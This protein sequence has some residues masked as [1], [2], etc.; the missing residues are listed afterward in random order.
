MR[1]ARASR[2]RARLAVLM[3]LVLVGCAD[4]P[5][6]APASAGTATLDIDG[7]RIDLDVVAC[8]L[9]DGRFPAT[10]PPT[11]SERTLVAAGETTVDGPVA[12]S[13]RRTRDD[14]APQHV[15]TVEISIGD[16]EEA[17]QALVLYRGLDEDSG[18]WS[19]I[20][21]D[22]ADP[23]VTVP[24]PLLELT[25]A[26]LR[27]EGSASMPTDG[28]RVLVRLDARCP[29]EVDGTPGIA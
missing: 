14:V 1:T 20:D 12:V 5:T 18:T 26:S 9:I 16:P 23:R 7:R 21:P 19:E 10:P 29:I 2:R 3:A 8:G 4:P 6:P 11:G 28:R 15:E 27:A 13:V 17:V 24:G 25:G 22:A